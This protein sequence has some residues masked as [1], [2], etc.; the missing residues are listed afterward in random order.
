MSN[1]ETIAVWFSCGAPSAIA[2][3]LTIEQCGDT[4]DVRIV[5]NPVIEEGPDNLR[6]LLDVAA[7]LGRPIEQAINPKWPTCSAVDVWE[8]ERYMSGINGAPCTRGLKKQ[9]RQHWEKEN[10]VDWH[11]LGFAADEKTRHDRFVLTERANVLPVLIEAG[12]TKADCFDAV[13]DA[14][15]KLPQ[16]YL[17]GFDNANCQGC[18]KAQSPTYWNLTRVV[19]PDVFAARAEMSRRLGVK[20]VK[21]KGQRIQLDELPAHA[22]GRPM[23]YLRMPDCGIFCEEPALFAENAKNDHFADAGKMVTAT[24]GAA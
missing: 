14:G 7:W 22:K 3:K 15:L 9:A 6:F 4:H 20:L 17:D 23:K 19:Y 24:G 18:V 13:T 10:Q 8:K 2:A 11:V 16:G 12:L 5:N 21:Y 1:R